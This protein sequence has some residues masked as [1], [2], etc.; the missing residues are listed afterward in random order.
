[1]KI[2]I[3]FLVVSMVVCLSAQS[4]EPQTTWDRFTDDLPSWHQAPRNSPESRR[5]RKLC[6]II[7]GLEKRIAAIELLIEKARDER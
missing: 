6:Q 5:N 7:D 1:M 3:M 4:D 2:F